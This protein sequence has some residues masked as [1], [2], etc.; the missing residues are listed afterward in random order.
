MV[1]AKFL[2]LALGVALGAQASD[3]PSVNAN[4]IAGNI[5]SAD[6]N[7]L[8]DTTWPK[9]QKLL[10]GIECSIGGHAE[11]KIASDSC[12]EIEAS[13]VSMFPGIHCTG[14]L[15]EVALKASINAPAT[16]LRRDS[17]LER[18]SRELDAAA[19]REEQKVEQQIDQKKRSMLVSCAD[20]PHPGNCYTCVAAGAGQAL[21]SGAKC[22]LAFHI[23]M[24]ALER[25]RPQ[26]G[27]SSEI[28]GLRSLVALFE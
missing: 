16:V 9:L 19:Q 28:W 7:A 24:V 17:A 25:G 11:G 14:N 4:G 10:P 3:I 20:A 26:E 23:A 13:L 8:W 2:A 21:T 5:A 22:L 12:K 27:A 15:D 18:R 1:S 6:I